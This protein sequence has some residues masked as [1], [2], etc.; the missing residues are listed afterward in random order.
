[1]RCDLCT[2][3][4]WPRSFFPCLVI[5][6]C[7]PRRAQFCLRLLLSNGN[8]NC[9]RKLWRLKV[10]CNIYTRWWNTVRCCFNNSVLKLNEGDYKMRKNTFPSR[11]RVTRVVFLFEHIFNYQNELVLAVIISGPINQ[12]PWAREGDISVQI[13]RWLMFQYR[14]SIDSLNLCESYYHRYLIWGSRSESYKP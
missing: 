4:S 10:R 2:E 11:W 7:I 9:D 5:R 8:V 3:S 1:M 12:T 6:I 14:F 13:W